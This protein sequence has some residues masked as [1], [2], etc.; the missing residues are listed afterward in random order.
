MFISVRDCF[1]GFNKER[2][3]CVVAY[4]QGSEGLWDDSDAF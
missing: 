2:T 1:S 4:Q 3:C